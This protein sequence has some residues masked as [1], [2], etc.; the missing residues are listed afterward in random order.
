MESGRDPYPAGYAWSDRLRHHRHGGNPDGARA[1][2]V[3]TAQYPARRAPTFPALPSPYFSGGMFSVERSS[4]VA[5]FSSAWKAGLPS[6]T[7]CVA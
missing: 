3:R 1:I 7:A 6:M 4:L 2:G 5:A